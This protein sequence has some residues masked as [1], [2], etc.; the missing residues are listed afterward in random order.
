MSFATIGQPAA[1]AGATLLRGATLTAMARTVGIV[2]SAGVLG[3]IYHV[4]NDESRSLIQHARVRR[5]YRRQRHE[6]ILVATLGSNLDVQVQ[7]KLL[8]S[9]DT[10][11]TITALLIDP[12]TTPDTRLKLRAALQQACIGVRPA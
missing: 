8:R 10:F 12:D 9:R 1:R 2:V 11:K 6:L 4:V 3:A 7:D 5:Q